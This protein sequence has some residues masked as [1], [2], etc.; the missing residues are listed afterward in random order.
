M[1]EDARYRMMRE[2]IRDLSRTRKTPS[3]VQ[4]AETEI[5]PGPEPEPEPE[6]MIAA[7][8]DQTSLNLEA[9]NLPSPSRM[10]VSARTDEDWIEGMRRAEAVLFASGQ[11]ISAQQL[12]QILPENLDPADILMALKRRYAGRGIELAEVAGRW[13]FQTAQDLAFLFVEERQVQKKLSQAALE[14]LAIIAYGQPVTRAEIEDV[15]GIAVSRTTL[16]AL[17]ETGWIRVAGRRQTP[18]RPETLAT[19][20][21]FLE[22]FGLEN[23][24]VLPGK[25]E[26][27]ADGLLSSIIPQ[28]F[29]EEDGFS[30]SDETDAHA[31]ETSF[32]EGA[33]FM[34]DFF[35]EEPS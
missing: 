6:T 8:E 1:T 32:E 2:A 33:E 5:A 16:D 14:I 17:M 21:Q 35:D 12:A 27:E 29:S 10:D 31:S 4:P 28:D 11:S 19:T 13:R 26:F 3:N 24:T 25:A 30:Y 15:R 7:D 9:S 34:A 20:D 22:H 23:L 18:G